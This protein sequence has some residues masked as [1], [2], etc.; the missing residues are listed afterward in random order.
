MTLPSINYFGIS[1]TLTNHHCRLV[2]QRLIYGDVTIEQER[3]DQL[4]LQNYGQHDKELPEQ[5]LQRFQSK[6][7]RFGFSLPTR[8]R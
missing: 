7:Q 8:A 5:R 1:I 3:Y 4:R 6:C 2:R